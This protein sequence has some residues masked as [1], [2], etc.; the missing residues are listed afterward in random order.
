MQSPYAMHVQARWRDTCHS[1]ICDD[2]LEWEME[3][4]WQTV[5]GESLNVCTCPPLAHIK[6]MMR[7]AEAKYN[8]NETI[9][10]Y[11]L[12]WNKRLFSLLQGFPFKRWLGE[13]M[14][15]EMWE[16]SSAPPC[17][18]PTQ[19]GLCSYHLLG[20]HWGELRVWVLARAARMSRFIDQ[21]ESILKSNPLILNSV[22][23]LLIQA[24]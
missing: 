4:D 18:I 24:L 11:S 17:W 3:R 6:W 12:A 9:A 21:E 23:H 10:Y 19:P 22:K 14:L 20:R 13:T 15:A 7:P 5:E 2:S 16:S 8:L 1:Q